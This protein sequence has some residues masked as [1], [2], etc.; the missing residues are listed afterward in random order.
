MVWEVRAETIVLPSIFTFQTQNLWK[1]LAIFC[2]NSPKLRKIDIALQYQLIAT[3]TAEFDAP[4]QHSLALVAALDHNS[5]PT[6]DLHEH[7]GGHRSIDFAEIPRNVSSIV[8]LISWVGTQILPKKR[9]NT[10]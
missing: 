10:M 3:I 1:I 4:L 9:T 6:T 8:Y 5:N 7:S 2:P